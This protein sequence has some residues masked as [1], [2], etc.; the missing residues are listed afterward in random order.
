MASEF[1]LRQ[2]ASIILSGGIISY[3]TDTLYGLSCD[4]FNQQAIERLNAIKQRQSDKTFILITNT[5]SQLTSLIHIDDIGEKNSILNTSTPTS[6][7]IKAKTSAPNWLKVANNTI[8]IRLSDD[9]ITKQLCQLTKRPL[10]ST[11]ANIT[12][13]KTAS[14]A[15]QCRKIFGIKIDTTL[16]SNHSFTGKPSRLLRL[17]DNKVIRP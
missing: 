7:I 13:K 2:A 4:P 8:A 10:V 17:C 12:G 15:L 6:W 9:P 11:S 5:L 1:Q 3:Q 14:N 16:S